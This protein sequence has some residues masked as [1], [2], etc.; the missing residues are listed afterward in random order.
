MPGPANNNDS[1]KPEEKKK[2]KDKYPYP[3]DKTV[4][5]TLN[6]SGKTLNRWR[7]KIQNRVGNA[8]RTAVIKTSMKIYEMFLDGHLTGQTS[9]E[10]LTELVEIKSF[11]NALKDSF[12]LMIKNKYRELQEIEDE[13]PDGEI[14]NYDLFK[15]EIIRVLREEGSQSVYSLPLFMSM[16]KRIQGPLLFQ[17]L[18][19]MKDQGI[20]KINRL[21]GWELIDNEDT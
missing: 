20:V 7:E 5:I 15:D 8:G 11:L 1:E 18:K 17:V 9:E 13:L 2:K 19:R 4:K 6:V 3:E 10:I 21:H 12:D 14:P 16:E